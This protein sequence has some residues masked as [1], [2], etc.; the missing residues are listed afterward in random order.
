MSAEQVSVRRLCDEVAR[1]LALGELAPPPL[2]PPTGNW[3]D[4]GDG[5]ADREAAEGERAEGSSGGGDARAEGAAIEWMFE[6]AYEAWGA[7][8][9]HVR[10]EHRVFERDGWRCTVPGCTSYRNLHAH[11][12]TFRSAGG[13]DAPWNLTTLCAAHH[14]HAVHQGTGR[15]RLRIS[16]L[17]PRGLRFEMPL[18]TYT[19]GDVCA[20]R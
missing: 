18:S 12:I 19:A 7:N 15:S 9:R 4:A 11:H 2:D 1:A 16:G 17:A 3:D 6:H 13:C 5:G 8:D 10:R 20:M 14:Y